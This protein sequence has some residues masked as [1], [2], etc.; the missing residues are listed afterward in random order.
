MPTVR[1]F[2]Q[3][4]EASIRHTHEHQQRDDQ[5]WKC[6]VLDGLL[7][8]L[9]PPVA[10][11]EDVV[12]APRLEREPWPAHLVLPSPA[13]LLPSFYGLTIISLSRRRT[14]F[15]SGSHRRH[16]ADTAADLARARRAGR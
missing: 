2:P 11:V 7:P 4:I 15:A 1:Y 12:L 8:V 14:S 13:A 3:Q 5:P 16:S 10:V 9:P 6:G